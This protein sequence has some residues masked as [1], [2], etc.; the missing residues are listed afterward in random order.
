[1]ATLEIKTDIAKVFSLAEVLSIASS[2]IRTYPAF[3]SAY[4]FGPYAK[5]IARPDSQI[6]FVLFLPGYTRSDKLNYNHILYTGR[7]FLDLATAFHKT[8]SMAVYP[9][10]DFAKK[11]K[12]DWVPIDLDNI[13]P[14]SETVSFFC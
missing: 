2:V 6:D 1:M 5:S 10:E 3:T 8:V 9:P 4:L 7:V 14:Q 12:S 11:V 13:D